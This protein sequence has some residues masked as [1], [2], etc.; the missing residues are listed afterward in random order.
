MVI[1]PSSQWG[2]V[3]G[4]EFDVLNNGD[5]LGGKIN[6]FIHAPI[7]KDMRITPV[8]KVD[9]PQNG[10]FI[11]RV[12]TVSKSAILHIYLDD[13]EAWQKDFPTGEK[14]AGEWKD[15]KWQKQ[16]SIWQSDYDADYSIDV[17]AGKHTIRLENTGSD[18][19]IIKN[20]TLTNYKSKNYAEARA[21]G[22]IRNDEAML[23]IQNTNSNW[24]NSSKN[25]EPAPQENISFDLLGLP[26][27]TY[28]LEWWDTWAGT[29]IN[30]TEASSSGG[31]LTVNLAE[32][33][34]DIAVK[35]SK[36]AQ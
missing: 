13:K 9:Y 26:D 32:L 5:I 35:I 23:W 22:L 2:A 33:K 17:P 28:K 31:N 6:M 4:K 10:K 14:G 25:I 21:V 29:I 16:W 1:H 27:G 19:A 7:K 34:T 11:I 15:S 24:Y 8:L 36:K 30:Q 12:G 3:E 20:I 18:W